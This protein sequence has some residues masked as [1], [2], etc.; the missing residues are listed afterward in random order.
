MAEA[1]L[2]LATLY[3]PAG[4]P[5]KAAA[6]YKA[7]LKKRPDYREPRKLEKHIAENRRR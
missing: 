5:R 7:F 3:Q 4:L 6:E 1:H 2:G